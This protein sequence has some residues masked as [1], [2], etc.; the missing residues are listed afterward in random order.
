MELIANDRSNQNSEMRII[1]NNNTGNN[2]VPASQLRDAILTKSNGQYNSQ[3]KY[4]KFDINSI[5][6][7][8]KEE[9]IPRNKYLEL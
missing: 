2:I 8:S 5:D 6:L 4:L 1:K 7:K 3:N 9:T